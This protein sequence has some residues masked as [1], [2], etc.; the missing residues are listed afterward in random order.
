MTQKKEFKS[1]QLFCGIGG[2]ALGFQE[3]QAQFRGT[4][5]T[6]RTLAGID[7]DPAGIEDFEALTGARGVVMD[8]FTKEDYISF[9]GKQPPKGWREVTP[10]ELRF[11]CDNE[12]PD[13]VFLS[14]PCK[15]FSALLPG[16]AAASDKYQAL[17]RLVPRGLSLTLAAFKDDP[18]AVIMIENV[19]RITIRGKALLKEVKALLSSHGYVFHEGYHDCGELGGLAQHRRRYL[20]IA[21]LKS[22]VPAFVYKPPTKRVRAIGEV[23]GP[24][25]LPDDV[26]S[27]AMHKLPRLQWKTWV[28]LALI[29][30]GGDWR[31]LEEF[32][33]KDNE[34]RKRWEQDGEK[35]AGEKHLFKGKY[36]IMPFDEPAR[37]IIGGGSNGASYLADPRLE[38]KPGMSG[39]AGSGSYGVQEWDKAGSTVIGNA[40]VNGST[41]VT[42]A[43]PRVP[44]KSGRH[45]SHFKVVKWVDPAGTVTGASHVANGAP[46]ISDPRLNPKSP[47]FNHAYSVGAWDEP[48]PTV[49]GGTGPSSGALVVADPRGWDWKNRPGLCGVQDW[50]KP[51]Q[52]IT[53]S[54][55]VTSSNCPAAI[56][57]PRFGCEA[58]SGTMQVMPW[59]APA[60]TVIGSLDIHAGAAAVSDPRL[61][62]TSVRFHNKYQLLSWNEPATTVTGTA[63]IQAGAQSV[64]DPRIPEDNERPDPPPV[65]IALDGTWHRPLTTLELAALQGFPLRLKDGRPLVL[66]GKSDAKWRE[67]I[68]N[69]VPPET[70]RVIAEQIALALLVSQAGEWVLGGTDIWVKPKTEPERIE[71]DRV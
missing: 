37:T 27:G 18:P 23:I 62:E 14:P 29:P 46:C 65:I 26:G 59:D 67:R 68:G 9:H 50:E 39:S 40:R 21:R 52:T 42:I 32:A 1:L 69:A 56:A 10:D 34:A 28:R 66:A 13:A 49:A 24:M 43:D 35:T 71:A 41:P 44:S 53:G 60:K 70:A 47:K 25:P 22:K 20:L 57:D 38:Y 15:G 11:I 33:P 51:A 54:A 5:G 30:A 58:R 6:W 36:G 48:A 12:H 3:S 31:D 17:N 45:L 64:A 4:T 8:L 55:S 63:D 2:A 61:P 7:C 19:P 16:K